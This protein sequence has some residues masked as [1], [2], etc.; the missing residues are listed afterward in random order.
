MAIAGAGLDWLKNL[1]FISQA[2][3]IGQKKEKKKRIERKREDNKKER[4]V[5]AWEQERLNKKRK[6]RLNKEQMSKRTKILGSH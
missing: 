5:F 4:R 1:G 3:D 6:K 2:S